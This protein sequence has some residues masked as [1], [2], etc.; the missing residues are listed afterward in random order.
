MF[1]FKKNERHKQ[2]IV[3]MKFD[4]VGVFIKDP[5]RLQQLKIIELTIDDLHIIRAV[6][7]YVEVRIKE[8]VEAF[9]GTIES[10]PELDRKSVV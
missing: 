2:T 7:P 5:S 3:G 1:S 8:V 10:V 4:G 9:Y 6:K